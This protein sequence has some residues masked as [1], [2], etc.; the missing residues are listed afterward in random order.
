MSQSQP[1]TELHPPPH[2]ENQSVLLRGARGAGGGWGMA[3]MT[4]RLHSSDLLPSG[5]IHRVSPERWVGAGQSQ[6][7][8]AERRPCQGVREATEAQR[9]DD[10]R[11]HDGEG[12]TGPEPVEPRQAGHSR[13]P[14][15]LKSWPSCPR[16][17]AP[18]GGR[19]GRWQTDRW[20]E[21]VPESGARPV[22]AAPSLGWALP[23]QRGS[24]GPSLLLLFQLLLAA[25]GGR[26]DPRC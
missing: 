13:G 21:Q 5:R 18:A 17:P 8:E 26:Q 4:F 7:K 3:G 6:G 20:A 2:P 19:A 23:P 25:A 22:S 24:H 11:G 9:Q 10:L 1:E 16:L 12:Q 15:V 14:C